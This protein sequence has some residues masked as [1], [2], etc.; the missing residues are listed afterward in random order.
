VG[1]FSALK[2]K[3]SSRSNASRTVAVVDPWGFEGKRRLMQYS[4]TFSLRLAA[5]R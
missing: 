3:A 5:T 4:V 1:V 2:G